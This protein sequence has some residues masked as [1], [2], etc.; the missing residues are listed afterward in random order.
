M[1]GSAFPRHSLRNTSLLGIAA[2]ILTSSLIGCER[3]HE[4]REA[5]SRRAMLLGQTVAAEPQSDEGQAALA[6]LINMLNGESRFGR[7]KACLFLGELGEAAAP[8]LPDLMRAA[9]C[10]DGLIEQESVG[11]IANMGPAAAPAMD[12]L[13]EIVEAAVEA[14]DGGLRGLYAVRALGNI[15]LPALKTV[16]LLE[17][18]SR[19]DYAILAEEAKAAL[20]NLQHLKKSGQHVK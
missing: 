12:L 7:A 15:G 2:G 19:S 17:L 20:Q 3:D 6:E 9:T 13:T 16:P 5:I 10:G 1:H 18:A 14:S 11:A 8:A 4:D